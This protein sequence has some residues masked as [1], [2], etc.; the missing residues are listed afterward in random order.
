MSSP[1]QDFTVPSNQGKYDSEESSHSEP[2][3]HHISNP[4]EGYKKGEH[5]NSGDDLNSNNGHIPRR[6]HVGASPRRSS[7]SQDEYFPDDRSLS[8]QSSCNSGIICSRMD[9][10]SGGKGSDAASSVN[11]GSKDLLEAAEG[12]IDELRAEAKMWERNARKLMLDLD[13]LRNEFLDQSKKQADLAAEMSASYA[14]RDGLK[15]EIEL[16]KLSLEESTVKQRGTDGST[17][18][19]EGLTHIQKELEREIKYQQESNANLALQLRRSQESNIQLV[20]VLQELEE[21]IEQQK[22]EIENLSQLQSKYPTDIESPNEQNL[23]DNKCLSLHLQQLQESEKRLQMN[24]ELLEKALDDKTKE[25]KN[26][27]SLNRQSLLNVEREYKH[28]LCD[29]DDEIAKLL[30]SI[31]ERQ[32]ETLVQNDATNVDLVREIESLKEKVQELERDCNE[33]TDENLELLLKLKE[34]KNGSFEKVGSF[35]SVSSEFPTKS[36]SVGSEVSDVEPQIYDIELNKKL[37]EDQGIAHEASQLFVE[38]LKQIEVGFHRL[39]KPILGNYSSAVSKKYEYLHD[40]LVNLTKKDMQNSKLCAESIAKYFFELNNLLD[41]RMTEFE[42]IFKYDKLEI[43]NKNVVIAESEKNL[44]DYILKIQEHE[45]ARAELEA[46]YANMLTELSQKVSEIEKLEADL[47]SKEAESITLIH[48]QRELEVQISDLEMRKNQLEENYQTA[49]ME[50]SVTSKCMDDLRNDLAVLGSSLDSHV[51]ANKILERKTSELEIEKRGLEC[52]II[53]LEQERLQLQ[54]R[55]SSLDIQVR[56]LKEENEFYESELK[57]SESAIANLKI[58]IRSLEL[59]MVAQESN[60]K[61][62]LHDTQDQLLETQRDCEF[63]RRDNQELHSSALRLGEE[64][65]ILQTLNKELKKKELELHEQCSQL[66]AQFQESEE[67]F[68]QFSKRIEALEENLASM[69]ESFSLKEKILQSELD[70]LLQENRTEKEKLNR[71]ETLWDE[72]HL[73]M[74]SELK[75]MQEEAEFLTR[76]ISAVVEEKK[77]VESEASSKISRLLADK[78]QLEKTLQEA[79]HKIELSESELNTVKEGSQREVQRLMSEVA[80]SEQSQVLLKS[81]HKKLLKQMASYRKAE[82]NLK[83]ALND[84]EL[85]L[86]VSDY[87]NQQLREEN[88]HMKVQYRRIGELQDEVSYFKNKIEECRSEKENME[89][90]LRTISGENETLRTEKM[91]GTERILSLQ[92]EV[93]EFES[94]KQKRVALEEEL[95]QMKD[96]LLTKEALLVQKIDLEKELAEVKMANEQYQ[97]KI[98]HLEEA[99]AECSEKAQA[100]EVHRK[101]MEEKC[102]CGMK[103]GNSSS[104]ERSLEPNHNNLTEVLNMDNVDRIELQSFSSEEQSSTKSTTGSP[105]VPRE[106]YERTK[107]SLETELRD[108]RERY[109]H[110][111]LRFAEVEAQREDLVMKIKTLKTGKRWFS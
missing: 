93:S 63:L 100:L 2:S 70:A 40:N 86:T 99:L 97:K 98:Y 56:Q 20:S 65:K 64:C 18:Q 77:K 27:Q 90:S 58:Q 62:E 45:S 33:L 39:M 48:N 85:K 7:S 37:T 74:S 26:E 92:E 28:K 22:A 23:E 82:E 94:C 109:F 42:E 104:A 46:D 21:I 13:M 80:T 83:T 12:T 53:E 44:K 17:F 107:S 67:S 36:A 29:K 35:S 10:Q 101:L 59:D 68:C 57:D 91:S 61:Q 19:S 95:L 14:E 84:L 96:A 25:L 47:L 32:S 79:Y 30:K 87:E 50:S 24:V 78:T 66:E 54:E 51:S 1:S 81:E 52:K 88:V 71:Q 11:A 3:L 72:K 110:M 73:E 108:L 60:L 6:R 111:S 15:K 43:Q 5:L 89:A 4:V 41:E 16:L 103:D 49:Q 106:R 38:L 69:L 9:L 8:S 102:K 34:S 76:Q 75:N 105:V 31:R 55:V